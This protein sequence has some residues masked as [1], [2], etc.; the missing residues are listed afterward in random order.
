MPIIKQNELK[1]NYPVVVIGGGQAGLSM[2]YYLQQNKVEHIVIEKK[3]A[4]NAWDEKRWDSFTLVTPNW[5]C[6]LPGHHYSGRDP[7]GFMKKQQILD[8]LAAFA[9]KVDAPMITNTEAKLI[10]GDYQSGYSIEMCIDDLNNIVISAEQIVIAS[11]SYPTPVIPEMAKKIPSHIQQI[12]SEEYKNASQLEEGS[13]LVVGSGQSGTQIAE[14]LH[15]AGR[16]VF[17]AT[18]DSPRCARFYRGKDVVEW[19]DNMEYYKMPVEQHPLREGVRDNSN[20]YVTGRDGGRDI[21]LRHFAE[22]GMELYGLINDYDN[23]QLCFTPNLEKNLDLADQT[24]N[25]INKKIDDFIE[26]N[27]IDAPSGDVYQPTWRPEAEREH[28]N[29]ESSGITSIIWCIGFKPNFNW[30]NI[31]IF[32][33]HGY[34]QHQRGVTEYKGVYFVGLPWLYTWGSA[35]FSGIAKDTEYISSVINAVAEYDGNQFESPFDC[36]HVSIVL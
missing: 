14:D 5:Q 30:I 21:D 3:Q 10:S 29:L 18:G 25:N 16:K 1:S 8:Y 36:D 13:V 20:H 23:G 22:Q 9:K 33:E 17:L 24:Y 31:P 19:L 28:I 7:N 26:N 27:Q 32:N 11:G 35:R 12:H 34:P 2:S 15:I 4:M 6:Q